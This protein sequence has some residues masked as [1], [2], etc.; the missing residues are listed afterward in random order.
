MWLR[1]S[2]TFP[3][4]TLPDSTHSIFWQVLIQTIDN[5]VS[6]FTP[7][8]LTTT[9]TLQRSTRIDTS[10][11][12]RKIRNVRKPWSRPR[13]ASIWESSYR[14]DGYTK[15]LIDFRPK[16]RELIL[17]LHGQMHWEMDQ[18]AQDGKNYIVLGLVL[19]SNT[20]DCLLHHSKG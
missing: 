6:F 18:Q 2:P 1:N 13:P 19:H 11:T 8:I 5:T 4:I 3:F 10:Q 14:R 12:L 17:R 20:A 7:H 9:T 16:W 15:P